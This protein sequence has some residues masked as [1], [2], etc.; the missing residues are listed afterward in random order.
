MDEVITSGMP[1]VEQTTAPVAEVGVAPVGEAPAAP[2]TAAPAVADAPTTFLGGEVKAEPPP[3][4]EAGQVPNEGGQSVEPAP[5]PVFEF[6]LPEG[7][8]EASE[9]MAEFKSLLGDVTLKSRAEAEVMKEF[10]QKLVD[11]HT[12]ELRTAVQM[13][14]QMVAQ[15]Y[16]ETQNATRQAW[17]E[18]FLNDPEIGGNRQDTTVN[19]A[20]MAVRNY[21]TTSTDPAVAQR[22]M[23]EF[24]DLMETTGVGDHPAL[25]RL[26][27]NVWNAQRE[28]TP[29]PAPNVVPQN[30]SRV[31]ALYGN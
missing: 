18:A 10:G 30:K 4:P 17:K 26:L 9:R 19:S 31:S 1:V 6:V 22:H 15:Q 13:T 12:A 7:V 23:A 8:T 2:Q 20:L 27:S 21:V 25:I 11:M 29:L 28:G 16:A 3:Q 24:K 14:Q 5:P